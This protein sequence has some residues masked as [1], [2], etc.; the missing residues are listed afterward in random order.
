M[1]GPRPA[2]FRTGGRCSA[3]RAAGLT[4]R[5]KRASAELPVGAALTL[6][7]AHP[8][9]GL[10]CTG[11]QW[12]S[13][14]RFSL[15]TATAPLPLQHHRRRSKPARHNC[16]C[17]CQCT[18]TAPCPCERSMG[19]SI[20]WASATKSTRD[21]LLQNCGQHSENTCV[22]VT[23]P[24]SPAATNGGYGGYRDGIVL[25]RSR[26]P[27]NFLC[28]IESQVGQMGT[29][30]VAHQQRSIYI[31]ALCHSTFGCSGTEAIRPKLNCPRF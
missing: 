8:P 22:I 6:L 19:S 10:C 26:L 28:G 4:A 7:S 27:R 20:Y 15:A 11:L 23:D 14:G 13:M 29:P 16:A 30:R 3:I 25:S 24:L 9:R 1:A 18:I 17:S 2:A 31:T 5:L 21:H 12:V